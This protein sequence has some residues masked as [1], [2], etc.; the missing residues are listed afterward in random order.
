MV[1]NYAWHDARFGD[2]EQLFG[3]TPTQLD[4]NRL[5]MSPRDLAAL[6][7]IYDHGRGLHASVVWNY[8]G[9]RFMNKRLPAR[10]IEAFATRRF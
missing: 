3:D 7:L 5:E 4:G 8:I 1:G 6:G 2:Y 9:E 10:S